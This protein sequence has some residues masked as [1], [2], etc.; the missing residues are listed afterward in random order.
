LNQLDDGFEK[1]YDHVKDEISTNKLAY[2]DEIQQLQELIKKVTEKSIKLQS[3]ELRN[4][5]RLEAYFSTKK[6]DIKNFK[7]SSQTASNYYKN[8][9]NQ[10]QGQAYF[11]DKK[12]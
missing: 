6:K 8:M 9:S 12:N 5:S 1:V 3:T 2:K 4:K 10:Q 11:L 7:V